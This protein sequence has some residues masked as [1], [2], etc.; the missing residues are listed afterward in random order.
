M[1]T[2]TSKRRLLFAAA[3]TVALAAPVLTGSA[4]ADPRQLSALVGVGSD[5]TDAVLNGFAGFENGINY[6]PVQSSA[7]TGYRQVISFDALPPAGSADNCITPKVG[8][9]SFQRPNG[10]SNGRRALSRAFDGV[11]VSSGGG[12]GTTADC[13][14]ATNG[15]RQDVS[16]LI[17]FARSSSGPASGDVGTAL[18][19]VPFGRDAMSFAY[20]R[21]AGSPVTSLTFADLVELYTGTTTPGQIV[22]SNGTENVTIIACGIQ[23]GSG[24]YSFWNGVVTASTTAEAT[25]TA[26]CNALGTGAR[27]QE[28]DAAGLKAKGDAAATGVQVIVG[29]SAGKYI[30]KANGVMTG[31]PIPLNVGLGAISANSAATPV[32]LGVPYTGTAPSLAP[33]STFYAD[34]KFGRN[35]YNVLPSSI[36]T[37]PGNLD[38]KDLFVGSTS[39][40]CAATSTISTFGFLPIGASCGATTVKGSFFT[41]TQ[42]A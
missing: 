27:V 29:F 18:T 42:N 24:S 14:A 26:T 12:W 22:R 2:S 39:K 25:A 17:D 28:H 4:S 36:V 30:A 16:G 5:T 31:D 33:S 13:G 3:A 41:G 35:V 40:I 8:G 10:S 15:G 19:Y 21:A 37:G 38:I 11:A 6:T 34:T 1:L 9:P 7:A 32:D 20:Y 23:L